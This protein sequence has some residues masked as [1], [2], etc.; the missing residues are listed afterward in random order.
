MTHYVVD[1]CYDRYIITL[2]RGM[3]E[4][5]APPP[6]GS[7]M[8]RL[9]GEA[10]LAV[11]DERLQG[12]CLKDCRVQQEAGGFVV[13]VEAAAGCEDYLAATVDSFTGAMAL[14]AERCPEALSVES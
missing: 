2:S 3:R 7:G 11:I 4:K 8:V 5:G 1:R 9:L 10:L 13:D 14:L 6:R 12:G